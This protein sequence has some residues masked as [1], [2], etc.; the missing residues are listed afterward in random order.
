MKKAF[1]FT[2]IFLLSS[3]P[4]IAQMVEYY[5]DIE[6]IIIKNCAPCHKTDG[7]APFSLTTFEEVKSKG[8]FIKHVTQSNYMPPWK[9]DPQFRSFKNERILTKE[10]IEKIAMWVDGGM[11]KGKRIKPSLDIPK[12]N[13]LGEPDLVLTMNSPYNLS[14]QAIEDFRFFHVPTNLKK[15]TFIK[16]IEFEPGSKRYVHHSRI[17]ADTT[18]KMS[19]IDGLAETDPKV[20]EYQRLPLSD[21]FLY[22]WVPGNLPVSYPGGTGKKLYANT[23]LLLNIHYSPSSLQVKDNSKIKLYFA[24]EEV[25]HEIETLAIREGDIRNQPFFI[26]ANTTPTF[27]VSYHVDKDMSLVSILPH[28]HY[29]GKSFKALALAPGGEAIPLI[30]I[31]EWDFNWQ[32]TYFFEEPLLI[33]EGSTILITAEYDNTI[34]NP[35]NPNSPPVDV[36]Y[37]WNSTNEMMNLVMYFYSSNR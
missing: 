21:E 8:N 27:Y 12:L 34:N 13:T 11:I 30:K 6:P 37:G 22:G 16:A 3:A 5:S 26:K 24:N 29:L 4:S 25:D 28:M 36:G 1:Y 10:E 23:D 33:P 18:N 20:L 35:A 7:Y 2:Y 31:D 15:T 17:M 9:A 14:N 32:S 19:G